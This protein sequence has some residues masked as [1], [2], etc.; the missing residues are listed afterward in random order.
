M[1][2]HLMASHMSAGSA[3]R[4]ASQSTMS[5]PRGISYESKVTERQGYKWTLLRAN[6][7]SHYP[8]GTCLAKHTHTCLC[9]ALSSHRHLM[10]A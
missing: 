3:T 5:T 6:E 1:P 8:P 10:G 7:C 2:R 9:Y 4:T